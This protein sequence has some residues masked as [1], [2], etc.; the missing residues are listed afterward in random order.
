MLTYDSP[1][2]RG[3]KYALASRTRRSVPEFAYALVTTRRVVVYATRATWIIN[4]VAL[5]NV[6]E[7]IFK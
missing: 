2:C 6:C 3:R 4:K 5:V 7:Q 1:Y